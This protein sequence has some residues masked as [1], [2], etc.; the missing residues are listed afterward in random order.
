MP[1]AGGAAE[2][3]CFGTSLIRLPR[4]PDGMGGGGAGA[5]R[6]AAGGAVAGA[7]FAAPA[8]RRHRDVMD[9]L[10]LG[11]YKGCPLLL[12]NMKVSGQTAV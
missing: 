2:A 1:A 11:K 9:L 5:P 3:A 12:Q 7:D 6:L 8:W 4:P 10:S